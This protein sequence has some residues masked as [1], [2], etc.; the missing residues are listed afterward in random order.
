MASGFFKKT[1]DSNSDVPGKSKATYY[2]S[3]ETIE[4]LDNAW[5]KLRG[6]KFSKSQI[7]DAAVQMALADFEENGQ[8]SELMSW[9]PSDG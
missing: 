3:D 9:L 4:A 1:D 7:V 8:I 2:I 6:R 5:L